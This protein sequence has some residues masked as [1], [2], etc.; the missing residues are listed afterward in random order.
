MK[1][2]DAMAKTI[3]TASPTDPISS[4][5]QV[6]KRENAGFVPI[7]DKDKVVGVVTD[8]DIVIRGIAGGHSNLVNEPVEQFMSRDVKTIE[9]N[10]DIDTAA[11]LMRSYEVRRL[12]VL[13]HGRIVGILSHGNLVQA[14]HAKG[15][16]EKATLGV[17]KGA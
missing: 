10:A 6:M 8:R 5:A 16:A 3:S 2:S 13:D 9:A 7:C 17:T 15:P 1:V 14:T 12:P 4:V 11:E